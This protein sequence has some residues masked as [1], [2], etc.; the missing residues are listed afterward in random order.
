M[1]QKL[2][3]TVFPSFYRHSQQT[4]ITIPWLQLSFQIRYVQAICVSILSL[5]ITIAIFDLRFLAIQNVSG[6]QERN[7]FGS[8]SFFF[9]LLRLLISY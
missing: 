4:L 3:L 8:K 1:D 5:G 7:V 9:N 6:K 2:C